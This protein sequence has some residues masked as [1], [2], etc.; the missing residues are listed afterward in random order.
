[1]KRLRKFRDPRFALTTLQNP[2]WEVRT[3]AELIQAAQDALTSQPD[4]ADPPFAGRPAAPGPPPPATMIPPPVPVPGNAN[5]PIGATDRP[6]QPQSQAEPEPQPEPE[7][8]P[9]PQQ[10]LQPEP[11]S[12][13]QLEPLPI[14]PPA[15]DE[16]PVTLPLP[17]ILAKHPAKPKRKS[18]SK[19]KPQPKLQPPPV[20]FSKITPG[21]DAA[22]F[23]AEALDRH[24]G[25]AA[26]PHRDQSSVAPSPERHSRKC[27]ICHHPDRANLEEDFLNWRNAE[28]IKN[29]Y[30][31]PNYRTIYLH[32]R[33]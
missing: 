2:S 24:A 11:Q 9:E 15:S 3:R 20:R 8:E 21:A 5:L 30:E 4:F 28:L 23:V 27:A 25:Q 33:A 14:A 16:V 26:G 1:M 7:P 31:L 6:P 10:E 18:K 13:P 32:A 12:E 22:E 17:Q 29:E 19:S